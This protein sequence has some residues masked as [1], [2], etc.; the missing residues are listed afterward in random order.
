M[1]QKNIY[2]KKKP[3]TKD[4][5]YTTVTGALESEGIFRDDQVTEF[6]KACYHLRK[7]GTVK[8]KDINIE[9]LRLNHL[10]KHR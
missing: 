8:I 4:E 5:A 6:S 1:A 10:N 9:K 2:V 7:K 3:E